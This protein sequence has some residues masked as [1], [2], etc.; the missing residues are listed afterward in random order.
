M[1]PLLSPPLMIYHDFHAEAFLRHAM[2]ILMPL[3]ADYDAADFRATTPMPI[4]GTC[5]A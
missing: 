1:A 2:S 4:H 3:F 5:C